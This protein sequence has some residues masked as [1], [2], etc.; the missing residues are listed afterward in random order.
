MMYNEQGD[1]EGREQRSLAGSTS[2]SQ[3]HRSRRVRNRL[4]D[5][6]SS[7]SKTRGLEDRC[8]SP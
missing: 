2:E 5:C 8:D 6:S 1:P 7:C 3:R 4:K